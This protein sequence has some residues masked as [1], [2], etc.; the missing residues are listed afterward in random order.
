MNLMCSCTSFKQCVNKKS[1]LI[2]NDVK[3]QKQKQK[4]KQCIIS[5]KNK[6]SY[7]SEDGNF[8]IDDNDYMLNKQLITISP[9]GY[10]GFYLLGILTY[11]KDNYNTENIIYSG[12]S[13]GAW[14]S[15]FMCYKGDSLAFV[16][17]F[18]D[19]NSIDISKFKSLTELQYFLKYKIL[20]SY[21]TDDFDLKKM[22][23]GVTTFKSLFP[24]INIYTDFEDLEDAINC[25][26][27]SSHI[28][29]LTGG[30]TN[31]YKDLFSFDGGFSS[32][33]YLEK[34]KILH[35]SLSMWE[36]LDEPNKTIGFFK[37]KIS[38]IKRWYNFFFSSKNN[39]LELFDNGYQ[40]AKTHKEY[41]DNILKAKIDE[42]TPEF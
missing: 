9:G 39:L 40:D 15:L 31:R 32:Y 28:P 24:V 26:M 22:F 25:C 36:E 1:N 8:F 34:E 4:Q 20:S 3:K 11:L 6:K 16:Y 21:K 7:C 14:N 17:N 33:P 10:K 41:F 35:I 13:A 19:N 38:S 37:Q 2:L 23:V 12:A 18:L 27:A 29:L 5:S 42:N 30:V